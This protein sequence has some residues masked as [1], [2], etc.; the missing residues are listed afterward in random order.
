MLLTSVYAFVANVCYFHDLIADLN[1]SDVQYSKKR[2][3]DECIMDQDQ[4]L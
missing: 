4:G 2:E 1:L 3:K